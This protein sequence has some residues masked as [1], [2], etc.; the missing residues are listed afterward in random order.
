MSSQVATTHSKV[1]SRVLCDTW[2]NIVVWTLVTWRALVLVFDPYDDRPL[3][4]SLHEL[5]LN[6]LK[7]HCHKS[8]V[9][10]PHLYSHLCNYNSLIGYISRKCPYNVKFLLGGN[11]M[12]WGRKLYI[13]STTEEFMWI[14]KLI[15]SKGTYGKTPQPGRNL[16]FWKIVP[17]RMMTPIWHE[18]PNPLFREVCG[19]FG[20]RFPFTSAVVWAEHV[21]IN[22][23]RMGRRGRIRW[24]G[25]FLES[26]GRH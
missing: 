21:N 5:M 26:A 13:C 22:L 1:P 7:S 23:T 25:P 8:S 14:H 2:R 11:V 6:A 18:Q 16:I 20:F 15:D 10:Y 3:I 24:F 12:F 19:R 9:A 4:C 17:P